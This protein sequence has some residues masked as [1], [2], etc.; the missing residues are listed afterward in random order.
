MDHLSFFARGMALGL[1]L[2]NVFL[3]S[4]YFLASAIPPIV[5]IRES[6]RPSPLKHSNAFSNRK[7][8][9]AL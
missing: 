7:V 1:L 3:S 8:I 4:F 9:T 6:G 2:F 5:G